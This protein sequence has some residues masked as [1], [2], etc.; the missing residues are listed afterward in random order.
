MQIVVAGAIAKKLKARRL[1]ILSDV[2]G[3]LDKD[4]KN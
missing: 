4:Q 1:L 2:E 3:V